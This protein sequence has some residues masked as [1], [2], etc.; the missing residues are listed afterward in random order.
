MTLAKLKAMLDTIK[1]EDYPVHSRIHQLRSFDQTCYIKREDELGCLIS[2]SKIRKYRTLIP[3]LKKSGCKEV[4]LI[5]SQHSNHIL[6]LS[7]LLIENGFAITLFLCPSHEKN[8]IG[9]ALFSRLLVPETKVHF[10]DRVNWPQVE[11]IALK[12]QQEGKNRLFIPEGGEIG[13]SIAGLA[14]LAIDIVANEK[15]SS[16]TFK[17]LF[18]DSGTGLTAAS[19]ICA[20]GYIQKETHIHVMLAASNE[21]SFLQ[22]L[23]EVKLAFEAILND[24][25][26]YLPPFTLHLPPTAK[27]F[28]ATN[29]TLFQT[30]ARVAKD[31]GLFLEPLYS[32][33]LYLLFVKKTLEN[34]L[35]GPFLFI[36]SGGLF[37]LSGFQNELRN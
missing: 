6:G 18:I 23:Q 1:Q 7:S 12:W 32:S 16:I 19:L 15:S 22:K 27:S 31:E 29:A 9:N 2:G 24:S 11:S 10:V 3:A 17:E 8:L 21:A 35:Q 4:A 36:H 20:F 37:S 13:H 34:K 5:G 26:A 25:I 33:K 30:I 28:G 14:T